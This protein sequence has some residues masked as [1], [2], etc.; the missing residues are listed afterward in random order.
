MKKIYITDLDHTF[1]RTDLSVSDFTR[2]VWNGMAVDSIVSVATART[3]K[4][5]LQFIENVQINAP[6]I[7]LDGALIATMDKKIID[8]KFINKVVSDAI[9]DEGA[10]L[11][12]YP[13]ILSLADSTLREIFS[14]STVLNAHQKEV[15]KNYK[16]DDH[17]NQQS[18]LRAMDDNFKVVYFGDEV[19][20]RE[21]A[22]QV[23]KIFGDSLKYILAPEAYVGC[24]FL[25]ILHKDADKSH[26]I[27][28]VSEYVGFDLSKLTVF[29][30]NFNDVGMFELA[31]TSVAVA[32]AQEGVK[33]LANIVLP[34]TN[35][36]DAVA[37]YLKSLKSAK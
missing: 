23:E 20:L 33:K 15:L 36:E 10:R 4:K 16:N 22:L 21:L 2:D 18:D 35:D 11:G 14:Y 7:L 1:L 37:K 13:F 17:H 3:Y 8:T 32:N 6:M 28:S 9:I 30:D 5:T 29:G 31:G 27:K 24:Y 12:I 26:G 34:H 19:L 25:T